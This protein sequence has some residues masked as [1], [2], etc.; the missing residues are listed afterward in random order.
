MFIVLAATAGLAGCASTTTS[1]AGGEADSAEPK[2][3]RI[4]H[5]EDST[6]SRVKGAWICE[7]AG[8]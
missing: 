4:C 8:N 5:R 3:D 1:T 7:E 6:G 2:K